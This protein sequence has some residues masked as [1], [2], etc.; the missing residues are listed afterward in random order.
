MRIDGNHLNIRSVDFYNTG[1]QP[2]SEAARRV[3]ENRK[4]LLQHSENP[5]AD[6]FSEEDLLSRWM[7]GRLNPLDEDDGGYWL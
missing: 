3:A 1:Q 2:R 6:P 5:D 7:E 4:R